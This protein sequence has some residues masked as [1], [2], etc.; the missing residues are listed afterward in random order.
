MSENEKEEKSLE[1][2][3]GQFVVFLSV[4]VF[5]GI[6]LITFCRIDVSGTFVGY[7]DAIYST[8]K[9]QGART[10]GTSNITYGTLSSL[11]TVFFVVIIYPLD[12]INWGKGER[13]PSNALLKLTRYSL[14]ALGIASF[15]T[16]CLLIGGQIIFAPYLAFIVVSVG[17][18]TVLKVTLFKTVK[19]ST[20]FPAIIWG[21]VISLLSILALWAISLAQGNAYNFATQLDYH[22]RL[23]CPAGEQSFEALKVKAAADPKF[24]VPLPECQEAYLIFISPFIFLAGCIIFIGAF[25]FLSR[26]KEQNASENRKVLEPSARV[27]IALVL[28]SIFGLWVAASLSTITKSLA[29]SLLTLS[30]VVLAALLAIWFA[31][32]GVE[33]MVNQ[34]KRTALG[35]KGFDFLSNDWGKALLVITSTPIIVLVLITNFAKQFVRRKTKL[36]KTLTDEREKCAKFTPS[37][38]KNVEKLSELEPGSIL[39]KVLVWGMLYFTFAVGIMRIVLVVLSLL[40]EALDSVSLAATSA[41]LVLTGLAMF[42]LPPVPGAPVYIAVGVILPGK[43]EAQFG[44]VGGVFFAIALSFALKLLAVGLQQK[45]IGELWGSKNVWVRQTVGINSVE[46]RAMR[47]ILRQPGLNFS[48]VVILVGGPDW[49]TSVLTGIMKLNLFQMLLGTLPVIIL[50]APTVVAGAMAA[51]ASDNDFIS[52]LSTVFLF[53]TAFIQG[54]ALLWAV[55][56]IADTAVEYEQELAQEEPDEE[57]L[58]REMENEAKRQEYNLVTKWTNL[59]KLWRFSLAFNAVLMI[60]SCYGFLL[61]GRYLFVPFQVQDSVATEL[62][63][64]VLNLVKPPGW[65]CLGMFAV[66]TIYFFVFKGVFQRRKP[67]EEMS[68]QAQNDEST[69]TVP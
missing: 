27:F 43:A 39:L 59:S 54:F 32:F 1:D 35:K 57:V 30:C 41:I 18:I 38:Q 47:K 51:R 31:V 22:A 45:V 10:I 15:L 16:S 24:R 14:I 17:T 58:E 12:V 7:G 60:V 29:N 13:S 42:L 68:M 50:I 65:I 44:F 2:R 20:F 34:L 11:V 48:K 5:S 4:L 23:K 9:E 28:L 19:E 52:T 62:G 26:T 64:N 66:S 46:I 53:F 56:V 69:H 61:L 25:I 33:N 40:R 63:G 6:Y 67:T 49:P 55:Q 21:L 37:V 36:G 8:L 3:V